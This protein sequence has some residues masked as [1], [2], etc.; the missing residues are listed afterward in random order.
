LII[1]FNL[2]QILNLSINHFINQNIS[3]RDL[4]VRMLSAF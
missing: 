2:I 3:L 1:D 4:I